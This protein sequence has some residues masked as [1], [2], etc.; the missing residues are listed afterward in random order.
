MLF[1]NSFNRIT[2][3]YLEIYKYD[4]SITDYSSL[5]IKKIEMPPMS[6]QVVTHD[7][8]AL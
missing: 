3:S 2:T 8:Y 5:V 6:E 4:E 7:R 1:S